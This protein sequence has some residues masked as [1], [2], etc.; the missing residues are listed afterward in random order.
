MGMLASTDG[1]CG[2]G[3]QSCFEWKVDRFGRSLRYAVTALAD[4]GVAGHAVLR[5]R[6]LLG[7]STPS[8]R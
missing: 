7:L 2:G 1:S 6:M 8:Q 3:T 4:L 5:L